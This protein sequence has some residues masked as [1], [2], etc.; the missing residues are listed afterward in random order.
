MGDSRDR[1]SHYI[2]AEFPERNLN[3]SEK[4]VIAKLLVDP[5]DVFLPPLHIK[6]SLMKNFF[7]A[8]N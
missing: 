7:K 4:N 8:M 5:K 1:N 3:P 2:Q 6:L